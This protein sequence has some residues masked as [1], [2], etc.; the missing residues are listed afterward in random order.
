MARH[1]TI[2]GLTEL[3]AALASKAEELRAGSIEAVM[4]ETRATADDARALAPVKTGELRGSI[5]ANSSAMEGTV[6]A[7]A[8]HATFVEHGTYKDPAQPFMKPAAD[9]ARRRIPE[10]AAAIIRKA[11]GA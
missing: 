7:T 9:K 11:L 4:M 6:K 8:R 1:V 10:T 2:L 5:D 3:K